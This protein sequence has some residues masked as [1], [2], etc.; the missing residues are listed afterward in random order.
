M[1]EIKFRGKAIRDDDCP[2]R[3]TVGD[4]MYGFVIVTKENAYIESTDQ[5]W[6]PTITVDKNT[7]GQYTG[8]KDD[9]DKPVEIYEGDVVELTFTETYTNSDSLFEFIPG[10]SIRG[11]VIFAGYT[12][13]VDLPGCWVPFSDIQSEEIGIKV[14]GNIHERGGDE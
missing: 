8:M 10:A 11:D 14:I 3:V 7:I 4:W 2:N 9:S 5:D 12:W 6:M 1:R 13:Y